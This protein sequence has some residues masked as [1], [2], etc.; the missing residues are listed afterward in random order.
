MIL[1][2]FSALDTKKWLIKRKNAIQSEWE[3]LS[4]LKGLGAALWRKITLKWAGLCFRDNE[5]KGIEYYKKTVWQKQKAW[6][7]NVISVTA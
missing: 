6:E 5:G 3:R 7:E 2:I 1:V 4:Q